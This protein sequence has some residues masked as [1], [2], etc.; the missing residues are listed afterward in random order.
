MGRTKDHPCQG[1]VRGIP[2]GI[3]SVLLK[4]PTLKRLAVNLRYILTVNYSFS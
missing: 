2:K 3:I 1:D 4:K